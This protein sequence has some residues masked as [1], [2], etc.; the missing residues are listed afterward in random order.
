MSL[1]KGEMETT[2]NL[3]LGHT[4]KEHVPQAMRYD[5]VGHVILK[6]QNEKRRRCKVCHSTT[7]FM[8]QKCTVDV[9]VKCFDQY[10]TK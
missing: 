5:N 6:S 1:L 9:H 7:V 8:C 2:P 3:L 10:H 4:S